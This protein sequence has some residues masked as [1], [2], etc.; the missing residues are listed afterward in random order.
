MSAQ[1]SAPV[2]VR[3]ETVQL[4]RIAVAARLRGLSRSRYMADAARH[5]ADRDIAR[6]TGQSSRK[7]RQE[8]SDQ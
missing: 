1:A 7:P 6:F 5:A 4:E 8:L 2:G 3:M